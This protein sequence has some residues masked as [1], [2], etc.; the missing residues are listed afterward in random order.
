MTRN[1]RALKVLQLI[2][3]YVVVKKAV[4]ILNSLLVKEAPK[5]T[6]KAA[7]GTEKDLGEVFDGIKEGVSSIARDSVR[8]GAESVP[9]PVGDRGDIG[10][11][12]WPKE[13]GV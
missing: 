12:P 13:E 10:S 9:Y 11:K 1:Q 8:K 3:G 7:D 2:G 5:V 4:P 6:V